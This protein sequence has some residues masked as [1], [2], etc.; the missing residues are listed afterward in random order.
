MNWVIGDV[1]GMLGELDSVLAQ[2]DK[3]DPEAIYWFVGDFCDRGYN[4][5]GV[6]D[7]VISLGERARKVRGNH[8]D[9]M[10]CI[11]SGKP[12][13]YSDDKTSE[14]LYPVFRGFSSSA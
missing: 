13:P 7:R 4:S 1:H 12:T 14:A 3:K 11:V 2:I 8:D 6:V 10:H 9:V 5:K